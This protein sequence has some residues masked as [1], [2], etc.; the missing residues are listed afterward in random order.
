[1]LTKDY[2]DRGKPCCSNPNLHDAAI[3][4]K[5]FK[6]KLCFNCNQAQFKNRFMEW[7]FETFLCNFWGGRL[8]IEK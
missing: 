3:G 2:I 8:F 7:V 4:W 5:P 1:M 6:V